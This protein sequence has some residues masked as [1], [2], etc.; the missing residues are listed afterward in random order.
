MKEL[1]FGDYVQ[2]LD[3]TASATKIDVERVALLIFYARRI[4]KIINRRLLTKRENQREVISLADAAL[5]LVEVS[6]GVIVP[7]ERCDIHS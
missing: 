3:Q 4:G 2:Q 6:H 5:V 1:V 7:D